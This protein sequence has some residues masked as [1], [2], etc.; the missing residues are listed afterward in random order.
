MKNRQVA[1][2]LHPISPYQRKMLIGIG[3]YARESR[4]WGLYFEQQPLARLPDLKKWAGDG[5]ILSFVNRHLVQAVS[6]LGVPIVGIEGGD[7][8]QAVSLQIPYFA[9]DNRAIGQLGAEHL[10][11]ARLYPPGLLRI[12]IR[13]EGAVVVAPGTSV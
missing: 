4:K 13:T 3:A 7:L 6:R 10:I 12:S 5:I 1:I 2:I 11:G 8:W 9:S